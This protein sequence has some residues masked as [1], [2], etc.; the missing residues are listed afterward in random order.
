MCHILGFKSLRNVRVVDIEEIH[1]KIDIRRMS[2]GGK[3]KIS[4]NFIDGCQALEIECSPV[5]IMPHMTKHTSG[6]DESV[7]FVPI[8]VKEV[9]KNFNEK[10]NL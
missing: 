9:V 8:K 2:Y 4:C 10:K 6:H 1:S 5:R 7:V 3:D